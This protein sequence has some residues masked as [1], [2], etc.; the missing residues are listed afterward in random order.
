MSMQVMLIN[1]Y[2][3]N[4]LVALAYFMKPIIQEIG[5]NNQKEV[6]PER[7]MYMPVELKLELRI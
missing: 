5:L 6:S 7:D 2:T 1:L 4:A 3:Q